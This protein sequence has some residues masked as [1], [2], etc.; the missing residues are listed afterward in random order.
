[1]D[2]IKNN[3]QGAEILTD[4]CAGT[5]DPGGR[6]EIETHTRQ[7][8]EC[9]AMVEAQSA[10]WEMLDAWTPVEASRNFDARLYARIAGGAG[11]AGLA[12]VVVACSS[13]PRRT[14]GGS[15]RFRWRSRARWC[16]WR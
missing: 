5:L 2:C 1:M 8:A 11:R 13:R 6:A 15:R 3:Q 4:Y 7:C 9:R 10:V 14:R 16:R 12:P